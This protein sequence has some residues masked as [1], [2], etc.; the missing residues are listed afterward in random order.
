VL[1][2]H[3]HVELFRLS[4]QRFAGGDALFDARALASDLLRTL[5]IV[6]E[7]GL[8]DLLFYFLQ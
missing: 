1:Q 5:R 8:G 4:V 7:T 3:Q 2:L 6:P